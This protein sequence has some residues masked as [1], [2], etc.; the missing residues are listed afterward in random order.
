VR[1]LN[2]DPLWDAIEVPSRVVERGIGLRVAGSIDY[3]LVAEE[4]LLVGVEL[5]CWLVPI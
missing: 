5:T 4:K 1:P 2:S 3:P